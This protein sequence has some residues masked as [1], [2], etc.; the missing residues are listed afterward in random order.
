MG[1]VMRIPS[2]RQA[3]RFREVLDLVVGAMK[4]SSSS[5]LSRTESISSRSLARQGWVF[6]QPVHTVVHGDGSGGRSRRSS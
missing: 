4:S 1:A 6:G 5:S 3:R 2:S